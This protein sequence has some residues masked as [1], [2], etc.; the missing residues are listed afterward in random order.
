MSS[1]LQ[2]SFAPSA[3]SEDTFSC[4]P[5]P[6]HV[7]LQ[8]LQGVEEDFSWDKLAASSM[9]GCYLFSLPSPDSAGRSRDSQ[10][11]RAASASGSGGGW[12]CHQPAL[13]L[14][15]WLPQQDTCSPT[16]KSYVNGP[17]GSWELHFASDLSSQTSWVLLPPLSACTGS[18]AGEWLWDKSLLLSL[19]L[20]CGRKVSSR[21]MFS[22]N[23]SPLFQSY[24]CCSLPSLS[25]SILHI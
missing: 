24:A 5:Q 15:L 6:A 8:P 12:G 7:V 1:S 23:W 9:T 20:L 14:S 4:S 11:H 10:C 22:Q 13:C 17:F 18:M 16:S 25:A 21:W 2:S 3:S 19:G